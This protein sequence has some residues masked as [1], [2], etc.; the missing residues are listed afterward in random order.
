M[1]ALYQNN[2]LLVKRAIRVAFFATAVWGLVWSAQFFVASNYY[3]RV[4][5][6]LE[7]WQA[8]ANLVNASKVNEAI[9]KLDSAISMFPDNALYYQMLGQL[10]EWNAYISA[11]EETLLK[12]AFINYQRSLAIRPLWPAS[13]VGLA[14]VKWKLNQVDSTFYQFLN[15]AIEVGPQDA[16]VH[17]FVV[18]FGLANFAARSPE[19]IKM[20]KLLKHH[21]ELGLLNPHSRN[22]IVQS[23]VKYEVEEP[24]CRWMQTASYPVRKRIPNCITYD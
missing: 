16:V 6:Q 3:Y 1:S 2:Q 14:S 4:N 10:Y 7:S 8:N 9:T 24:A 12:G 18:E 15:Q 13:W 20:I 19:Y 23:I 17:K 5:N 21:M 22:E 11:N